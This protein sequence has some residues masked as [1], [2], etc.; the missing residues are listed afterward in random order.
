MQAFTIVLLVALFGITYALAATSTYAIVQRQCQVFRLPQ[1]KYAW[2]AVSGI[3]LV[4]ALMFVLAVMHSN[5]QPWDLD[6]HIFFGGLAA[7][8]CVIA[9]TLL[10]MAGALE[11][12]YKES[13]RLNASQPISPQDANK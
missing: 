6:S 13:I 9:M 12:L 8:P 1:A 5:P 7:G 11:V 2:S 3:G 4:Y 10:G